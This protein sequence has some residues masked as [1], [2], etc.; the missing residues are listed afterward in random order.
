MLVT[1]TVTDSSN[2]SASISR[3]IIVSPPYSNFNQTYQLASDATGFRVSFNYSPITANN[4]RFCVI[5]FGNFPVL[6]WLGYWVTTGYT[7]CSFVGP[8]WGWPWAP[9]IANDVTYLPDGRWQ[10]WYQGG[11]SALANGSHVELEFLPFAPG[12]SYKIN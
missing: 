6:F 8:D 7:L 12:F 10:Q 4:L 1:Y 11:A 5:E 9:G 3:S 2:L